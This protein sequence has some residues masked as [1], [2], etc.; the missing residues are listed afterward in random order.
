[1]IVL[2]SQEVQCF[3]ARRLG[4]LGFGCNIKFVPTKLSTM[5]VKNIYR[6]LKNICRYIAR[7][8]YSPQKW[9]GNHQSIV[10]SDEDIGL[11]CVACGV[12]CDVD[13]GTSPETIH[14]A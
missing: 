6:S 13:P 7:I 14:A 8:Y 2:C 9:F 3:L 1:M 10:C 11:V 4:I 5:S 12:V